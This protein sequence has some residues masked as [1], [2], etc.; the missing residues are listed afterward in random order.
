M[1]GKR[2]DAAAPR[3]CAFGRDSYYTYV[4]LKYCLLGI[5][6]NAS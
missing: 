2:H 6:D 1:A 4:L 5:S 3:L